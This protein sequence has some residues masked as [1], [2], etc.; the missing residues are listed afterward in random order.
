MTKKIFAMFLAVL[1]VVSMLP[2]SVFAANCPAVHTIDNCEYTLVSVV[3]P[4]CGD[5]GYTYYECNECHTKFIG[6]PVPATGEHTFEPTDGEPATCG[7]IGYTAGLKCKDCP[8]TKDCEIIPPKY[9]E[10]TPCDFGAWGPNAFD[11]TQDI[12]L[13]RTCNA[14]G[15]VEEAK[16]SAQSAHA[17]G[18]PKVKVA[19]TATSTG[20]AVQKCTHTFNGVKCNAEREIVVYYEHNH[21]FA[22]VAAVAPTCTETGMAAYSYCRICNVKFNAAHTKALTAKEIAALVLP[23]AHV[24]KEGK[25]PSCTNP[26]GECKNCKQTV[27]TVPHQM[28]PKKGAEVTTKGFSSNGQITCTYGGFKTIKCADCSYFTTEAVNALGHETVTVTV[29]ATCSAYGY[30]FTYCTR[31]GCDTNFGA[32]ALEYKVEVFDE[33]DYNDLSANVKPYEDGAFYIAYNTNEFGESDLFFTGS[34]VDGKMETTHDVTKAA[35][36]FVSMEHILTSNRYYMYILDANAEKNYIEFYETEE[37]EISVRLTK[38]LPETTYHFICTA[39]IGNG[40]IVYSNG[41]M[42]VD[43]AGEQYVLTL[44]EGSFVVTELANDT[45]RINLSNIGTMADT[46]QITACAV[47][48]TYDVTNHKWSETPVDDET[49]TYDPTCTKDGLKTYKCTYDNCIATKSEVV[50][51]THSW[52][53]ETE[54]YVVINGAYDYASKAPTCEDGWKYQYCSACYATYGVKVY[55]KI[56]FPG[57]GHKYGELQ[58]FNPTHIAT[59]GYDKYVCE[60][61][62]GEQK[63][64]EEKIWAHANTLWESLAHA[65]TEHTFA[66]GAT[67]TVV[68]APTCTSNGIIRMVCT[69]CFRNVNIVV[70]NLHDPYHAPNQQAPTCTTKGWYETFECSDPDCKVIIGNGAIGTKNDIAKLGHMMVANRNYEPAD[71]NEPDWDLTVASCTRCSYEVKA[72]VK[73]STG[74]DNAVAD[75]ASGTYTL[76]YCYECDGYHAINFSGKLSHVKVELAKDG[77][78]D[79]ADCGV[80]GC[81]GAN[82]VA[83][84]CY[85]AGYKTYMCTVCGKTE[86]KA[87][88]TIE[89]VNAAGEKFTNRCDD[90]TADRHCVVCCQNAHSTTAT[91]HKYPCSKNKD[92]DGNYLCSCM[93]PNE[94]EGTPVNVGSSCVENAYTLTVCKFCSK[95]SVELS[96]NAWNGHKPVGVADA[97]MHGNYIYR[98]Y[99]WKSTAVDANG[100]FVDASEIIYNAEFIEYVPATYAAD[101]YWKGMCAEC[102][103]IVTQKMPK[104][105]GL[106]FEMDLNAL[107][108]TYGSLIEVIISVNGLE[109]LVYGFNFDVDYL[110]ILACDCVLAEGAKCTA[111]HSENSLVFVGYEALNQNFMFSVTKPEAALKNNDSCFITVSGTSAKAQNIEV[112]EKTA[113]IKLYFRQ[114]ANDLGLSYFEISELEANKFDASVTSRYSPVEVNEDYALALTRVMGDFNNDGVCYYADLYDAMKLLTGELEDGMTYDVTVDVD[115]DGVITVEDILMLYDVLV[116][117]ADE[118]DLFVLGMSEEEVAQWGVLFPETAKLHCVFC[119]ADITA[120]QPYCSICFRVNPY[121][122]LNER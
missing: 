87:V 72:F 22:D 113:L 118:E 43:F 17:W 101:G 40:G 24:Y 11:C 112:N 76:Y 39:V 37:G 98:D 103:E 60:Y 27:F 36:V 7:E 68:V 100:D 94:H 78:H 66:D 95:P 45:V 61:C 29:P 116:G 92:D 4:T 106:G 42:K 35:K 44:D 62:H 33:A 79:P 55:N 88:A 77:T 74:A 70:P 89:H 21:S 51:A 65:K 16:Q 105:S 38:E 59:K 115:K 9:K 26:N 108:Y 6:S 102:D 71:C 50:P 53:D 41:T 114:N 57:Y 30:T 2:T 80:A 1:M 109:E 46:T 49:L 48:T 81:T 119:N 15:N 63:A 18:E 56:V 69:G 52:V 31:N 32:P 117:S 121:Y 111:D 19:A 73:I 67:G 120:A 91:S 23:A 107:E 85:S 3:A 34:I 99:E 25:V 5:P 83:S 82:T 96:E 122:Q 28:D 97:D 104:L 75:C 14:C 8:E 86:H 90:T 93:I 13:T 84:T 12:V 54:T 47:G 20:I 110:N 64:S 10:G 58:V